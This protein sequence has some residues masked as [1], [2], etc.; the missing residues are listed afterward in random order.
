MFVELKCKTNFSFLRGAS[1]GHEYIT[2]AE[3]LG[4]SALGIS[5]VNGVY[6]LPRAYE[7]ILQQAKPIKLLCGSDM[8]IKD[9]PPITFIPQN[10]KVYGLMCRLLTQL[11][12][13]KEKGEG[14]LTLAELASLVE[15]HEGGR[16]LICLP[17]LTTETN[18]PFL[19]ELFPQNLYLPLCR[20]LDGL[21]QERTQFAKKT[22]K[23]FGLKIFATNDV[24]YHVP[25]RRDLQDCVTCIREGVSVDT[26][27]FHLF[28]NEQRYLKSAEQMQVLF[29]DL[30]E[31]VSLTQEISDSCT[32]SLSEIKYS[33]PNEFI[34][35]GHTARS[36]LH[37][38]VYEGAFKTYK[39]D[40]P[41]KAKKLIQTELDFFAKRGDEHYFLT[42]HDIVRYANENNIICQ[43]RGSAANSIVCFVLGITSV[44]PMKVNLLFD[45]FMNDGRKDPPDIDIDF[46]YDRREEVIQY[47][48]KRFGRDR[49][50]LVAT[51]ST[52]RGDSALIEVSKA[53]GIETGTISASELET[54]FTE[55]AKE[56]IDRQELIGHLVQELRKFPRHLS[57][58]PGGFV[59]S[60]DPLLE[61]VP[62]EPARMENRTIIQWDKDDLETLGLMKVD[63]LS[64][65]FLTTLHKATDLAGISWREI[66][67]DDKPT[68]QMIQ[69]GKTH[70][71]FQIESRAQIDKLVQTKP[72]N[73]YD[74]V[75][76]VALVRPS[77]SEG[78]MVQPYMRNMK[79][80]RAGNRFVIK[81][82][83]LD[84]ILQRT[85]GVPIFQ[86]QVMQISIEVGGFSSAEADQLRRSLGNQRGAD[87]VNEMGQRL[88]AALLRNGV[89]PDYAD[90][91]FGYVKGYAHYGF[92]E[93]HAASYASLA[94]KSAYM[95]CHHP[96][97]LFVGLDSAEPGF[98]K[99]DTLINEFKRDGVTFLPID[100]NLSEWEATI[101]GPGCVRLGFK[102]IRDINEDAVL[103]MIEQRK[104]S[105]FCSMEDFIART[106]F[107]KEALQNLALVK[108]FEKFGLDA[109]HSFWK[110]IEFSRLAQK[111]DSQLSLF[112]E[113]SKLHAE[114]NLFSKMTL[115]EE[116]TTDYGVM[117]Y[118]LQGNLMKALRLELPHLPKMTSA[119]ISKSR[120]GDTVSFAGILMV[121]Q[122]PPPAKGVAFLTFEDEFG[123]VDTVLKKDVFDQ[124]EETIRGSRFLMIRGR[125]QKK[126]DPPFQG[127][128]VN[129][130][131]VESFSATPM[132]RYVSPQGSPRMGGK[133]EWD[134][135]QPELDPGPVFPSDF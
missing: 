70:G 100:P 41:E 35:P 30:P 86:E 20:Y 130:E 64:I 3:D 31:A 29:S 79:A 48:Y 24:H 26:A 18:V 53:M 92:P 121:I 14:F 23:H 2:R 66:P 43:G 99:L 128:S 71:T 62:I 55:L 33:Y 34:P 11:H 5:D 57:T 50:A 78:G 40:I 80:A 97:E 107:S 59:L 96:A 127:T 111:P 88:Y 113:N 119:Q 116:M 125:V 60:N 56:K 112:D 83:V 85:H 51:V 90:K 8:T 94:Y 49:A 1:W 117:G 72:E 104:L 13:G 76:Q 16:N 19:R 4:M 12:A 27:G 36:Y 134:A 9:H 73:Y 135:R 84:R 47:I 6:G 101:A 46:E 22:A 109:R 15:S 37:Q 10:R 25:A 17:H 98:Y 118:S 95:K 67:H 44:D 110:S 82:P 45:R 91:L 122:R 132:Y 54:R 115:L 120:R 93:S 106:R 124:F 131:H 102:N 58:H 42:V 61:I 81:H 126:G 63:I 28:G 32:F 39:G 74:L 75:V 69:K 65:R 108:A 21:D 7:A 52:Y 87:N 114:D 129:V 123:S 133:L 38:I 77:P 68:F 103:K 105:P 89:E